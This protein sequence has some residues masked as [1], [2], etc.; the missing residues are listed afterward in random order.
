MCIYDGM[1]YLPSDSIRIKSQLSLYPRKLIFENCFPFFLY[2][3]NYHPIPWRDSIS[4]YLVPISSL[5][6]EDEDT[7]RPRRR[8]GENVF[9]LLLCVC[10][11][12]LGTRSD[13]KE[14]S[15][16]EQLT[17]TWIVSVF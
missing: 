2:K 16:I 3:N 15:L 14:S 9:F 8:K 5:A 13:I 1:Y 6:G 17:R 12:G 10:V 4:R 11:D 7:T